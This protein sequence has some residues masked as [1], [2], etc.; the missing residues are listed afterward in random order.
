[1]QARAPFHRTRPAILTNFSLFPLQGDLNIDGDRVLVAIGGSGGS[2]YSNF[3]P[4][5]GQAK[6]IRLDLKLIA[7]VGLVG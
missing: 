7:D 3:V 1:M 5:K 2:F 6:H 4:S